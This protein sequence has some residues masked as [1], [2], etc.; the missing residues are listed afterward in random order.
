MSVLIRNF[1]ESEVCT[2]SALRRRDYSAP[3]L[4]HLGPIVAVA[5]TLLLWAVTNAGIATAQSQ[6]VTIP[7]VFAPHDT[8]APPCRT[9]EGRQSR[10]PSRRTTIAISCKG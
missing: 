5:V 10:L 3:C 9:P 6:G 8:N 4:R 1:P 7:Q 2:S